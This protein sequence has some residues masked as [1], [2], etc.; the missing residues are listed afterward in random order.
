MA[1]Y[2]V[3]RDSE[4]HNKMTPLSTGQGE[5][6]RVRGQRGGSLLRTPSRPPYTDRSGCLPRRLQTHRTPGIAGRKSGFLDA[7]LLSR[8]SRGGYG[9]YGGTADQRPGRM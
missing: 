5:R 9:G 8:G 6:A 2:I 1:S 3:S 4:P 7:R